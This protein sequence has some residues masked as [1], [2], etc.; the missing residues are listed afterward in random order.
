MLVAFAYVGTLLLTLYGLGLDTVTF[1]TSDYRPILLK[2]M[3]AA[4]L[5]L[6]LTYASWRRTPK[7][8]RVV[9]GV[10]VAMNVWTLF[11]A[12]RRWLA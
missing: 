7:L 1:A 8:G 3:A 6:L 2:A 11:D 12:C 4:M 5:A 9:L 10:C